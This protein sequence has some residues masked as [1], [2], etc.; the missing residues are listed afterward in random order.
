[1]N[2]SRKKSMDFAS[3]MINVMNDAGYS[4]S[5]SP[6]GIC[7]KKLAELMG[8]SEQICRRYL[9]RD[10]VPD[11]HKVLKVALALNVSPGWLLF[12]E[13]NNIGEKSQHYLNISDELLHYILEKSQRLYASDPGHADDYPDFVME[14]IRDVQS[15][16][17]DDP[18]TLKKIIDVAIGSI[19]AFSDH[20][21]NGV[22]G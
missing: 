18:E 16:N 11:H 1:M 7:V 9:R 12:G 6:S 21:K 15:I 3:R 17:T 10:A 2:S 8:V 19:C 22:I 4:D 5:R 14:L 20:L 13:Q